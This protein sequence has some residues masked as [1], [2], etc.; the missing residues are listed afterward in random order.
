[1]F[2]ALQRQCVRSSGAP[3]AL[4][5]SGYMPLLT[6][7]VRLGIWGYKHVAPPEQ[8]P[9]VPIMISFR[10]LSSSRRNLKISYLKGDNALYAYPLGLDNS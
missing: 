6:E 10:V 4:A 8:E 9:S 7:R 3:C 2:I 1:M 5:S